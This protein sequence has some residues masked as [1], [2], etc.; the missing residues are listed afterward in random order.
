MPFRLF[1]LSR[2]Q[3]TYNI[4]IDNVTKTKILQALNDSKL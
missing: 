3:P 1:N 2:T 4:S